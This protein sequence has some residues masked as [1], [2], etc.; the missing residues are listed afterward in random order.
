MHPGF[1]LQTSQQA[2]IPRV[3]VAAKAVPFRYVAGSTKHTSMDSGGGGDDAP[4]I[5]PMVAPLVTEAFVEGGSCIAAEAAFVSLGLPVVFHL[6]C[7]WLTTFGGIMGSGRWRLVLS[8]LH[9]KLLT[10]PSGSLSMGCRG[11]CNQRCFAPVSM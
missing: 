7:A 5:E 1:R 8:Y 4:V 2:P 3:L 10:Q 9:M 6:P 11:S